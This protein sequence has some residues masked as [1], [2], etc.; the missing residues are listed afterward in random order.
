MQRSN[1][2]KF[3]QSREKFSPL[4][5]LHFLNGLC[6]NVNGSH[7]FLILSYDSFPGLLALSSIK[8]LKEKS[9]GFFYLATIGSFHPAQNGYFPPAL[10]ELLHLVS[11]NEEKLLSTMTKEQKGLF[12]RYSDC[13]PE[14]RNHSG[15][16]VKDGPLSVV[17]AAGI[18]HE[19]NQAIVIEG[20]IR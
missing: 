7:C 6:Y 11:R 8:G 1:S 12:S 9:N 2:A 3:I 16:D 4:F 15:G 13:I 19:P 5:G 20:T 17:D 10:T 18:D 14:F